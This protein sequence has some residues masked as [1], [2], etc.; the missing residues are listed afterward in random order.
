MKLFADTAHMGQMERIA[1]EVDGFTTNPTLAR[2][3][4]VI[5][6]GR[7][8]SAIARVL[9]NKEISFEVTADDRVEM[10]RQAKIIASWGP[11]AVVKIPI[12][13]TEGKSM[14]RL[15]GDLTAQGIKVN[16]TAV[17]TRAQVL[18]VA[19][20]EPYIISIFAGRIADAG[21]D[22]CFVFADCR[23]FVTNN[24]SLLWA[25]PRQVYD[26]VLAED[27]GADIIT[28]TPELIAKLELLGKDLNEFSLE[29]VR[30]FKRDADEAGL[31]L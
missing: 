3:A 28:M 1:P 7:W 25:S 30:M 10:E 9:S 8:G 16:V 18:E 5:D 13:N 27:C 31:T 6:Y 29:T 2:K 11:N 4:G 19:K 14:T 20:A 17:F 24:T 15:I 23:E 12:T 21:Q 26:F 22:P